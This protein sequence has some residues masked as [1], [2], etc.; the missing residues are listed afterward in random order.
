MC[1]VHREGGTEEVKVKNP[2]CRGGSEKLHLK[3]NL[4]PLQFLLPLVM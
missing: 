1:N 4:V 3:S 2:S